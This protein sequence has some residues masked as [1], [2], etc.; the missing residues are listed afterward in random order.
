MPKERF[1]IAN[2]GCRASQSEGAAIEDELLRAGAEGSRSPYDAAVVVVNS[3]TVTE[4]A[5]RDVR[6]LIGR[7]GRRRPEARI[8]VTGCYAQ[9]R[10]DELADMPHVRYIV[11]NSH[12][13]MV[14]GLV[15][16]CLDNPPREGRAEVFCSDI[17]EERVL[18]APS[19]QGSA[20]RTRATV[21]VQD[22]CDANCAFCVIPMVRGRS[23][24]LD[25]ER[26]IERVAD[27]LDR[28]YREVVLSGIHL[29]SYGRDLARRTSFVGLVRRTLDTLPALER[30]R[31]SSIEPKEVTPEL[32]DLVAT[33]PRIARHLHV[34]MQSG[35][36]RILRR[37]RRP[38]TS[39]EYA[40]LVGCIRDAIP[41]AAIGADVMVGFPGETDDDFLDTYR[42]IETSDLT[43]LHVFPF[44]VRP[45]TAA[46]D[47]DD[48]VPVHVARFRGQRLRNLIAR[49][50]RAFREGFVG[51]KLD[52]L[53]LDEDLNGPGRSAISD[54]FMKVRVPGDLAV[55][56]WHNVEVTGL[57]ESG[58]ESAPLCER[59]P[60]GLSRRVFHPSGTELER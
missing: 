27:L 7:V 17:F 34:P 44:S 2:F 20:G 19:T 28:G 1:Y 29:G 24:S 18:E 22:G 12:K 8:I 60:H 26:V 10:P 40:A 52:V 53:T 41:D 11:G 51:R 6:R 43:Y 30:L 13:S 15:L 56:R 21:K 48:R 4:E 9:R 32:I 38:Y 33:D 25:P 5:D 36:S 55:N 46:A 45:G 39:S 37:M 58:L 47:M 59:H 31:L 23:R 50:N 42:L 14:G 57:T 35:S 16:G 54:N 49:K 3:C